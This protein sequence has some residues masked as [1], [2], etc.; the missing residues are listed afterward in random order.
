[1]KT[2]LYFSLLILLF[3][4]GCQK[5]QPIANSTPAENQTSNAK[6]TSSLPVLKSPML[7]MP[8]ANALERITKKPFAI[9]ITPQ[10][11]PVS[12]EKFKGYHTGTDFETFADEQNIEVPIFAA[13]D[14]KLI[15]KK[16]ASGYGGVIVQSC[17]LDGQNITVLY[18]HLR[19]NSVTLKVGDVITGMQQLGVLGDGYSAETDGERKH[20][21]L[22]MHKG[23]KIVLL[24]YVQNEKDLS[25]WLN[26]TDY[27]K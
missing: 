25:D 9:Y 5:T 1:M 15:L 2:T 16:Y 11:S 14:G 8:I 18:G 20:L 13:C 12:P 21:H 22:S 6:T 7:T 19:L 23:T 10:N 26:P 4:S 27:L 3:A 24:G 17:Q